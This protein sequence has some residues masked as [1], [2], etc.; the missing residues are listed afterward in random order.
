M[1]AAEIVMKR[2]DL[3][4]AWGFRLTGGADLGTPFYVVKVLG[5]GHAERAGLRVGDMVYAINNKYINNFT[6]K[7]AQNEILH[8]GDTL[9]LNIKRGHEERKGTPLPDYTDPLMG[10]TVPPEMPRP[11]PVPLPP[12]Q[13]PPPVM[14]EPTPPESEDEAEDTV[15]AFNV[16]INPK[17]R[18]AEIEELPVTPP[19]SPT[20]RGRSRS[21]SKSKDRR[22]SQS[23]KRETTAAQNGFVPVQNGV[24][25]T[26]NGF[27]HTQNGF[28]GVQNGIH[29]P[30][31][32]FTYTKEVI[33]KY[34]TVMSASDPSDG[35]VSETVNES[36]VIHGG[37]THKMEDVLSPEDIERDIF[38]EKMEEQK[39]T[40]LLTGEA[41]VLDQG[42]VGINFQKIIPRTDFIKD[43]NVFKELQGEV[44]KKEESEEE[45]LKKDPNKRFST[46]LQTPKR[47]IP[48]PK[49]Q[50]PPIEDLPWKHR[51]PTPILESPPA[52]Q[53]VQETVQESTTT[54][55]VQ[56]S[57]VQESITT[58]TVT[59]TSQITTHTES[60]IIVEGV[61]FMEVQDQESSIHRLE[62]REDGPI[63]TEAIS[64]EN[65]S[66]EKVHFKDEDEE[67]GCSIEE[68]RDK[69]PEQQRSETHSLHSEKQEAPVEYK[70]EFERQL[71]EIQK[72]IEAIQQLPSVLQ[73]NLAAVR[74]QLA[75][76]VEA[77]IA[78]DEKEKVADMSSSKRDSIRSNLSWKIDVTV[79]ESKCEEENLEENLTNPEEQL[80]DKLPDDQQDQVNEQDKF[81]EEFE[82]EFGEM[83]EHTEIEQF[84]NM[85]NKQYQQEEE[86]PSVRKP[87]M[88]RNFPKSAERPIVLPGGRKWYKPQDAYNEDF[89]A[90]TIIHQSE[91]LVGTTVGLNF[92]KYEPPKFDSA[93]SAVFRM[94]QEIEG[95]ANGGDCLPIEARPEKVM[96][97]DDYFPPIS[98][99]HFFAARLTEQG[100]ENVEKILQDTNEQPIIS[101]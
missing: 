55:T 35:N 45:Q 69:T 87:P 18:I 32:T 73:A 93:N 42:V 19:P 36:F 52:S 77:K 7:D 62:S 12:Y 97:K 41:E 29:G 54:E 22:R 51:V 75:K 8:T 83:V 1:A 34:S 63:V 38:E 25:H 24:E 98:K 46:F 15:A 14:K 64:T 31:E 13:P 30:G 2:D 85:K 44:L 43:S 39:L 47:P 27:D 89:I 23:S 16:K 9:T 59:E 71:A 92:L 78:A 20:N 61:T 17:G 21:R 96:A 53:I 60:V 11:K 56:E 81:D 101:V 28:E 26:Q 74:E 95:K 49:P 86:D 91:V 57:T 58:E 33:T 5:R 3:N 100:N 99:R 94:I 37:S 4:I 68:L 65:V 70:S 50:P 80:T 10:I 82:K 76:I 72:Q 40:E 6:H 66:E 88:I 84:K 67:G 48:K 90:E 79:E